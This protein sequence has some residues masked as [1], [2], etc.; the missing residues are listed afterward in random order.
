MLLDDAVE[1]DIEKVEARRRAPMAKQARLDMFGFKRRFQQGIVHQIDL[2]DRQVVGRLPISV[3]Q[4]EFALLENI[5]RGVWRN[6]FHVG[7]PF[8]VEG[9]SEP[10]LVSRNPAAGDMT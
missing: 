7:F 3:H 10:L 6:L 4:I 2:A 5:P 8:Q 9:H 1:M